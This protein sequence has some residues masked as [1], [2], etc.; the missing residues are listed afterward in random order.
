MEVAKRESVPGERPALRAEAA[1]RQGPEPGPGQ[2]RDSDDGGEVVGA[3]PA[4]QKVRGS[5]AGTHLHLS[6]AEKRWGLEFTWVN[7]AY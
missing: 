1:A 2:T 4:S 3:Q 6:R 5:E 7:P